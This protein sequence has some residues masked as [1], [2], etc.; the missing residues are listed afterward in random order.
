[1][2]PAAAASYCLY[3]FL[4]LLFPLLLLKLINKRRRDG[5]RAR[6]PPGPWRLPVIGS[7]HHLVGK[8]LVHRAMA[9]LARRLDAPLM[10]LKLGEVPVVVASSP[11]A[12]REILRAHDPTFATRPWTTTVKIMMADGYGPGFAPYGELWRQLRRISVSELLSARRVHSFRRVREDE[13]ARLVAAV[14]VASRAREPVSVGGRV[15]AALAD[16]TVRAMLGDRFERR[17]E[18]LETI[19]EANRLGSG[20]NLSDLFPSSRVVNLV[21]ATA[22]RALANHLKNFELM[23][24]AIKQHEERRAAAGGRVLEEDGDLLDVLLRI[25]KEGGLNVPLTRGTIK[26]MISNY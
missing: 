2:E 14:A 12:A 22:R 8:P 1:M 3:L 16:S 23:E 5:A 13:A 9:D 25:Q 4:A 7:L 21:T 11:D 18:F 15:A 24:C 10:Y 19:E 26:G 17:E 20:F 6:L